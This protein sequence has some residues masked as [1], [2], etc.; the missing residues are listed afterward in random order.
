[1]SGIAGAVLAALLVLPACV[2][3]DVVRPKD[4]DT[5]IPDR[6]SAIRAGETERAVVRGMLGE[7]AFSSAEWAFG[8]FRDEAAQILVPVALTPVP[9]LFGRRGGPG[10]CPCGSRRRTG[11]GPRR[12]TPG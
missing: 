10:S 8:L 3:V 2:S 1:M 12:G 11:P 6:T 7:P 4:A 9:E 5:A